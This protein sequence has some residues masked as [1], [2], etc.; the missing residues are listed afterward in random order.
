MI[1]YKTTVI[2]YIFYLFFKSIILISYIF[3][4]DINLFIFVIAL[5]NSFISLDLIIKDIYK[6]IIKGIKKG[7]HKD[8][9]RLATCYFS[10]CAL[11]FAVKMLNFCVRY[12]Y[13]CVHLA[14]ITRL[15][16]SSHSKL[17]NN[18]FSRLSFRPISI[19]PLNISLCLHS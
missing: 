16:L 11:S 17:D 10:T 1:N 19:S 5:M 13:R 2:T 6:M 7:I 9:N 14:F 8:T 15:P 3:T 4:F 18:F 12:G